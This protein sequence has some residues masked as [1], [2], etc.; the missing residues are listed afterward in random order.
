MTQANKNPNALSLLALTANDAATRVSVNRARVAGALVALLSEKEITYAKVAKSSGIKPSQLSRQL[1]GEAN[2]T[3]DTLTK[4]CEA[5]NTDYDVVFREKT[6]S[7]TRQWWEFARHEKYSERDLI[8]KMSEK[9]Y[10]SARQAF[11]HAMKQREN[12]IQETRLAVTEINGQSGKISLKSSL[13]SAN[14]ETEQIAA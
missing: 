10:A 2:L 9:L 14:D 11:N 4:I 7:K 8:L 6:A 13:G 1:S 12:L 5:V 3:L